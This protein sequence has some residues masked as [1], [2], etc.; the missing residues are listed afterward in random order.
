MK[1][2]EVSLA[3]LDRIDSGEPIAVALGDGQYHWSPED[4]VAIQKDLDTILSLGANE[5]LH[6]AEFALQSLRDTAEHGLRVI[7][8]DGESPPGL[9]SQ[10]LV[11]FYAFLTASKSFQD[12]A[13]RSLKHAFGGTSVQAEAFK[14]ARH[15]EFDASPDYRLLEAIRNHAQHH[16]VPL[17]PPY[18][19]SSFI[20]D[21]AE[22]EDDV[23]YTLV[24]ACSRN[25]LLDDR[26]V[27]HVVKEWLRTQPA[28]VPIL[29]SSHRY[30]L[31]LRRLAAHFDQLRAP[32]VIEAAER[33]RPM[34][35][36]ARSQSSE[37]VGF[38]HTRWLDEEPEVDFTAI[39]IPSIDALIASAVTLDTNPLER[40]AYLRRIGP[41]DASTTH[42]RL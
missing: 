28:E 42:L 37:K 34:L 8:A 18:V 7:V 20:A 27:K 19:L 26:D 11:L 41:T 29:G 15:T 3:V 9:Q 6:V 32:L 25:N 4:F 5:P 14:A 40:L 39:D 17:I 38:M 12:Q 23:S 33:L 24:I 31:A 10:L 30:L 22:D 36:F 16:R 35:D 13:S 2:D 21:A 1:L